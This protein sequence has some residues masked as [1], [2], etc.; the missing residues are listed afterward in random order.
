M[1]IVEPLAMISKYTKH[2]IYEEMSHIDTYM[3]IFTIGSGTTA[4]VILA[5]LARINIKHV[6]A[7]KNVAT[8]QESLEAQDFLVQVMIPAAIP[9]M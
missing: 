8:I 7:L 1:H 3:H 2:R 6:M 4:T 9:I 5:S